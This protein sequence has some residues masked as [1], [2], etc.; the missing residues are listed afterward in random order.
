MP[1]WILNRPLK[2]CDRHEQKVAESLNRLS[3]RWIVRWGF[4]YVDN[5]GLRREGDFLILGPEG[6][7]LVLEVK[8][9]PIR[10]FSETG[11]WEGETDHPIYQLDE[12]WSGVIR[13]MEATG[14]PLPLVKKALALPREFVRPEQAEHS[15]IPRELIFGSNDLA[16]FSQGWRRCFGDNPPALSDAQRQTFLKT[17]AKSGRQEGIAAFISRT[18]QL[19]REQFT[20]SYE[21]LDLAAKNRQL[22]VEGRSGSGKTWHA[23]EKAVRFAEEGDGRDVLMLCYNLALGKLLKELV[24]QREP[25]RG[26]I[27]V[28]Q[29]EELAAAIL[30]ECDL[31]YTPPA[32]DSPLEERLRFFDE[33]LPGTLLECI[34]DP[35]LAG[36]LP[37]FDALVVDEAQD[38][39]TLFAERLGETDP[40]LCGW[41]SIYWNLLNENTDA[42]MALF[43]DPSQRPPFRDRENFDP[44]KLIRHLSQPAHLRLPQSLRYTRP[45]FEFLQGLQSPGT[46]DLVAGMGKQHDLPEGPAVESYEC[47]AD[48]EKVRQQ[49]EAVLKNWKDR[50]A[51]DP[52]EVLILHLHKD[53]ESSP[54]GT[55]TELAGHRL[56]DYLERDLVGEGE[57]VI[58]HT[59]I[60]KAK[61]L[62]AT[63]VIVVGLKAFDRIDQPGYQ[64]AYFMG[65][66]RA[67]Q[68]LAMVHG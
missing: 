65:A 36:K 31:P 68:V 56:V 45:I 7:L 46:V 27:T 29:W 67:K 48:I 10:H 18:E 64:H 2:R 16:Q 24:A 55:C 4:Y 22:L 6:G 38:H 39:D 23:I 5:R 8:G 51:C 60:N 58:L 21:I 9:K 37:R 47:G 12:E 25:E 19:F 42:P 26:S 17:F 28:Y 66:S 57:K 50:G 13:E 62:D 1:R 3:D 52:C 41:W 43:Y 63:G 20:A 15:G 49:V 59:S 14:G 40:A 32:K 30:T 44:D 53:L 34:R 61:G 11:E 35:D 54:L 33:E